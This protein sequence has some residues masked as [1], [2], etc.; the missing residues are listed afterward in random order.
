MVRGSQ[1]MGF[2]MPKQMPRPRLPKRMPDR[3]RA[4]ALVLLALLTLPF[5]H[6][7]GATGDPFVPEQLCVN[8]EPGYTIEE[9]NQRWGTELLFSLPF[10]NLYLLR[11]EG[12][13]DLEA[14]AEEMNG[15]SAV[16]VSE[17]NYRVWSPEAVRQMVVGAIGG[18][19]DDYQDQ[20]I[21]ERIGLD[22]A[23][24][25]SRGAGTTIAI[26]DTGLDPDHIAFDGRL[27]QQG[28]DFVDGD[29]HPWETYNGIDDDGDGVTDAGYGHGTMVAGI[30][31]LVAPEATL[32]PVRVLNDEGRGDIYTVAMGIVHA[33]LHGADVIN[34][35]FGT[36]EPTSVIGI[37]LGWANDLDVYTVAG[38]GN[39]N[40]EEPPYYPAND[41]LTL[42]ITALDSLDVKADFADFHDHVVVSAP[43]VGVRSAYPEDEWGLG[44]GCSFAT[45][46]VTGEIALVL[47]L[48]PEITRAEML[49]RIEGAVDPIYH[50][51]GNEPYLEKLGTGRVFLP[52]SVSSA[53]LPESAAHLA[54]VRA[55]PNPAIG[56]IRFE[57]PAGPGPAEGLEVAILDAAGRHIRSLRASA[58]Q[59]TLRWSARDASGV[60]VPSGLYFAQLRRGGATRSLPLI[61]V[62]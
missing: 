10:D 37:P 22:D 47:S 60:A 59:Q 51:P 46:F 36:P 57:L 35:S 41:S 43:G 38:A 28:H 40:R 15:D 53:G 31:A 1:Q 56:P 18:T 44:S 12:I 2:T 6:G 4:G 62:R 33:L 3:H 48:L 23:H 54:A 11:K 25:R 52:L 27:S 42:M 13:D 20:Q 16:S 19:W 26:L 50:L 24:L 8:L 5:L 14:F 61:V 29:P 49:P 21:G 34:M 32:L 58:G 30:A 45:P 39:E 7:A 55:W 17:A 9:V